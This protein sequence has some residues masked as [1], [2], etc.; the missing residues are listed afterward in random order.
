MKDDGSV[1]E[2]DVAM[3]THSVDLA[4]DLAAQ[5]VLRTDSGRE[6]GGLS[7]PLGSGHHYT[8]TL[9]FP[10]QATDGSAVL[11]G[12]RTVTLTIRGT[13]V[14]ERAFTWEVSS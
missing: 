12:A 6:V 2:F 9:S 8:G 11:Q 14:P 13:D 5:S 3:N 4:W 1:I 7:W 10:G